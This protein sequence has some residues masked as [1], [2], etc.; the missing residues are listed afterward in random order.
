M[1]LGDKIKELRMTHKMSCSDLSF[2]LF[3]KTGVKRGR[4]TIENWESGRT[5]PRPSEIAKIAVFFGKNPGY[6]FE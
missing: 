5:E 4:K 2:E 6:F 3:A 1:A